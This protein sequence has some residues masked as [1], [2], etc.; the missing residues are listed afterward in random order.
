MAGIGDTV[1]QG[2]VI[3]IALAIG[4]SLATGGAVGTAT[5]GNI[6][7]P[8]VFAVVVAAFVWG[9]GWW[10]YYQGYLQGRSAVTNILKS[11]TLNKVITG[12]GVLGNFIMGALVVS[13]VKLQI[14]VAFMIGGTKFDIQSIFN[15]FMPNLLP[16]LLVLAIWWLVARKKVSPTTVMVA[17]I[18][19]GIVGS[20]PIWPGLTD[21]GVYQAVGLFK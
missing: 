14:G 19:I 7:G 3:P 9:V 11:G 5:Q 13:F 15:Q 12:A 1:Q 4:M 6:V 2:I 16:L 20:Y 18:L 8:I 17:I 21:K 10:L